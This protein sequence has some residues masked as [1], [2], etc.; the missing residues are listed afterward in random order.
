MKITF[1]TFRHWKGTMEYYRTRGILHVMRILG[2]CC[3][4]DIMVYI[5]LEQTLFKQT[6]DDFTVKVAE[7]TEG[8]EGLLEVGLEYVCEKNGLL[9]FR[10]RK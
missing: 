8:I 5:D 6:P 1:R 2:H 10:K 7:K 4:Q 9:Y 3:V